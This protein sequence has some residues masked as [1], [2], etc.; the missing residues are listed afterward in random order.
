MAI[1]ITYTKFNNSKKKEFIE[2]LSQYY[3]ADLKIL[4]KHQFYMNE[5]NK[6]LYILSCNV[7]SLEFKNLSG[8]GLYFGTFHDN[9]R[10]RVSIEGSKYIKPTKNFVKINEKN[11]SSY[12]SG[13]TL[14]KKEV[15]EIDW[16]DKC[17]FLIVV[18][19]EEQ[20][21]CISPKQDQLL[22]YVPK[23]R[24]LHFNKLY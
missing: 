19:E 8:F 24:R 21:G 6:K 22:N 18:Y 16:Q 5:R 1:N 10:F 4:E 7:D 13:E 12:L 15:E 9:D 20:L 14:F 3:G 11:L 23:S 17:P 2:K